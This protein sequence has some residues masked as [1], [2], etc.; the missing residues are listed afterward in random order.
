SISFA[1]IGGKIMFKDLKYI[2]KDFRA[3][4]FDGYIV[5]LYWLFDYRKTAEQSKYASPAQEMVKVY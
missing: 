5:I 3:D 2:T 4:V 1:P